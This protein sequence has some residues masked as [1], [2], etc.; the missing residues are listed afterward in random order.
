MADEIMSLRA[1]LLPEMIGFAAERLMELEV[2]GLT[3]AAQTLWAL[4]ATG[5]F[6]TPELHHPSEHDRE[7]STSVP[8][9]VCYLMISKAPRGHPSIGPPLRIRGPLARDGA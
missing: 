1:D 4:L 5:D 3:G 6:A 7:M 2:A 9:T 8:N